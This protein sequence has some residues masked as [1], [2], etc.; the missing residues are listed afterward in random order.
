MSS[1]EWLTY[2]ALEA[3]FSGAIHTTGPNGL[4]AVAVTAVDHCSNSLYRWD[5]ILAERGLASPPP[6]GLHIGPARGYQ[7]DFLC[8]DTDVIP[9]LVALGQEACQEAVPRKLNRKA[10]VPFV[11]MYLKD[12]DVNHL[13]SHGL[14]SEPLLIALD[15]YIPVRGQNLDEFAEGLPRK[16]RHTV[17]KEH[18]EFLDA[19][20][21]TTSTLLKDSTR[22]VAELNVEMQL[23]RGIVDDVDVT[24][25]LFQQQAAIFGDKAHVEILHDKD[26]QSVGFMLWYDK[27]D[28]LY[29]R[30]V[31]FKEDKLVGA[32]EYF[33]LTYYCAIEIAQDRGLNWVH[34]GIEASK[35]KAIR[36]AELRGLWLVDLSTD[37][38]LLP[39]SDDI[40]LKNGQFIQQAVSTSPQVGDALVGGASLLL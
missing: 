35:V 3:E 34:A 11:G 25:G 15:A 32:S 37:S 4:G 21:G 2:C 27:G 40:R 31:G 38:I 30:A 14:G 5:R 16:R 23:R 13:T 39:Y 6:C 36:G 18:G 28:T 20:Y 29:V 1:E 8:E 7:G 17:R 19:G 24:Q 22:T 9:D 12:H 33:N 26:G 10:P